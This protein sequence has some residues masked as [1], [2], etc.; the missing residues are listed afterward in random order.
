MVVAPR[1]C[2]LTDRV[3][4]QVILL[5]TLL[6]SHP[7]PVS[8]DTDPEV[9]PKKKKR[10]R[11]RRDTSPVAAPHVEPSKQTTEALELLIDPIAVWMMVAELDLSNVGVSA[12]GDG[13]RTGVAGLVYRFWKHVLQPQ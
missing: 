10:R 4:L 8:V 13:K 3:L 5:L 1:A 9:A 7:P 12:Q 2:L 6:A 11:E